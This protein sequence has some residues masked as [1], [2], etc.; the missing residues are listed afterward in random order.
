MGTTA[1]IFVLVTACAGHPFDRLCDLECTDGQPGQPLAVDQG[2]ELNPTFRGSR[3]ATRRGPRV[4]DA[5]GGTVAPSDAAPPLCAPKVD[6]NF[7]PAWHLPLRNASACTAALVDAVVDCRL[8]ASATA[9]ACTAA[10]SPAGKTC[11][12]CVMTDRGAAKYGPLIVEPSLTTATLNVPG[13]VALETGDLTAVGCG[14]K[15]AFADDCA[16]RACIAACPLASTGDAF[17][18]CIDAAESGACAPYVSASQC[19]TSATSAGAPGQVCA[20]DGNFV[21]TAKR[22]GR[23]FCT[24]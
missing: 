17:R 19:G 12:A 21:G 14:A 23:V 11:E 6:P 9:A 20:Y 24:P 16:Y 8:Q 22:L 1:A 2:N 5:D 13:C 7:V 15:M 18:S 10:N 4:T 3:V